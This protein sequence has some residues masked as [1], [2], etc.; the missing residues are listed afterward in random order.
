MAKYRNISKT[1][2]HV[3]TN[4]GWTEVKA[5]ALFE[6][7]EDLYYQ[8]GDQGETALFEA[9]DKDAKALAKQH[10]QSEEKRAGEPEPEQRSPDT[11]G[12]K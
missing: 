7:A 3:A 6:G 11:E 10:A 12:D 9:V 5:G 4:A 2:L 1:D 8:T